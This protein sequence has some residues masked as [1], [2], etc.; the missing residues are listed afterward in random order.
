M[1]AA[2]GVLALLLGG[3]IETLSIRSWVLNVYKAYMHIILFGYALLAIFSG[4]TV[5][6]RNKP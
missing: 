2:K 4:Y 3:D 1:P 5:L 6:V